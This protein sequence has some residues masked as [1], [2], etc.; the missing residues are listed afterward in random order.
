MTESGPTEPWVVPASYAQERVW[1]AAQLVG[2]S[3]VYSVPAVLDLPYRL[4]R[5]QILDALRTVVERQEQLRTAFTLEGGELR[6]AV[7]DASLPLPVGDLDLTGLP[8][9]EVGRRVTETLDALTVAVPLDTAPLWRAVLVHRGEA[10]RALVLVSSHAIVDGE[11]QALL[12][13]E[14][15]QVGHT[16][17]S[18]G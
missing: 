10:D 8:P 5:D 1:F 14:I 17:G 3:P 16:F 4:D 2:D 9:D 6:Q 15:H 11:G 12:H 18:Q 7:Y 13:A